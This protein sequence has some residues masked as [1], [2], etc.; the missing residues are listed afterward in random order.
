LL[1]GKRMSA[2]TCKKGKK[3]DGESIGVGEIKWVKKQKPPPREEKGGPSEKGGHPYHGDENQREKKR[4][5]R[6]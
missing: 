6:K 5:K 3:K 2:K 4:E 1:A